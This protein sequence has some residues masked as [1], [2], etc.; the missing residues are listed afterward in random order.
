MP[1]RVFGHYARHKKV[2]KIIFATGL[3]TAAA[4]F[5]SPKG[6]AADD[7]AGARAIDVNVAGFQSRFDAR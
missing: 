3:G 1:A 5:E 4:H 6:M 2:Q 7:R